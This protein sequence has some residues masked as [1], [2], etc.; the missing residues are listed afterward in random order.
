MTIK[1]QIRSVYGRDTVYPACPDAARFASIA[2]TKT[3]CD[4]TLRMVRQLGYEI[5]V[6]HPVVSIAA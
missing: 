3:L 1:V 5:E 2:G 6:V 4:H